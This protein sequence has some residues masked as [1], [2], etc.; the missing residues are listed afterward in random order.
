MQL[1]ANKLLEM[2]GHTTPIHTLSGWQ[3]EKVDT[4]TDWNEYLRQKLVFVATIGPPIQLT[5]F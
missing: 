3:K 5:C 1:L 2:Y 4:A